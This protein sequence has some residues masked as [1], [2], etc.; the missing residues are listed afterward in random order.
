[1]KQNKIILILLSFFFAAGCAQTSLVM[2]DDTRKFAPSEGV[3]ILD[4]TPNEPFEVIARL[5]TR[6]S[7]SQG[8]PELLNQMRKEAQKVGADAIIPVEERQE[9]QQQGLMYNPWL[10][11][12]QTIGGGNVPII[13]SYA[14][15]L[16]RSIPQRMITYRPDPLINGGV[17]FNALTP[18]LGG[19][20]FSGWLGKNR[21]R[22]AFDYYRV[23]IPQAMTRD[24]F[25]E[26]KVDNAV[27]LSF[28]Y[29]F[30]GNLSGPYFG[31]GFQY[32]NYNIG[33]ENTTE[34]GRWESIDFNAS[35]GY[36]LNLLPNIHLDA[37]LALDAMLFGEEEIMVG[38]NIMVPD[39][40]KLYALIG[41]GVHF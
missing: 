21:F 40:A 28:D 34:R 23:D 11:G 16:E 30:L 1:M 10:G 31:S 5:E 14:I 27:R 15:I 3:R 26:G 18:L 9:R 19:Y 2:L 20:G 41:F 4:Q 39:N 13:T 25:T 17:S 6:G 35:F 12:Y 22:A 33:H 37:R 24:G 8:I 29:F 7:V 36:K 38:N 32:A